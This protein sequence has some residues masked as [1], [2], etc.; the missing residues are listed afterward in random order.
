VAAAAAAVQAHA[1]AQHGAGA[2]HPCQ[3]E[4]R[5][6]DH[7]ERQ[8]PSSS[9]HGQYWPVDI[10]V[11]VVAQDQERRCRHGRQGSDYQ[12]CRAMA[13]SYISHQGTQSHP[14]HNIPTC[15]ARAPGQPHHQY[16]G[17]VYPGKRPTKHRTRRR[18]GNTPQR[19]LRQTSYNLASARDTGTGHL[20][21]R[22]TAGVRGESPH[23]LERQS[24]LT[25]SAYSLENATI[26]GAGLGLSADSLDLAV[27]IIG[28]PDYQ[29]GC[30]AEPPGGAAPAFRAFGEQESRSGHATGPRG[31]GGQERTR[32]GASGAGATAGPAPRTRP[33]TAGVFGHRGGCDSGSLNPTG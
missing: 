2:A 30:P 18:Q 28:V 14:R 5:E 20:V 12:A 24:C 17:P 25:F 23:Q 4:R 3:V 19:H 26:V 22:Q 32:D 16:I 6:H 1:F 10:R 21:P 31:A 13:A 11:R 7:R 8:C 29:S 9:T 33:G 27:W 15:G